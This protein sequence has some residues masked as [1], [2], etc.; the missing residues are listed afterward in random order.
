MIRFARGVLFVAFFLAG[1]SARPGVTGIGENPQILPAAPVAASRPLQHVVIVI[2]ENRSF[3]NFFATFPGADGTTHGTLHTGKVVPLTKHALLFK[4]DLTHTYHT[5]RVAYDNG[6]MDGFDLVPAGSAS[7]PAGAYNYAYVDPPFIAPYWTLAKEYVLADH[8]F[9]TQGSGSF[10]AH[11]DLIAG[12]S[13][14][15]ATRS[16][17]DLPSIGPPWGCDSPPGTVTSLI[18]TNDVYETNAGPYPCYAYA[19]LRDLLDRKHV[20]WK[21]YTPYYKANGGAIWNAFEAIKAVRDGSEWKTNVSEPQTNVFKDIANK[22]LPAVSWV[23]PQANDSDHPGEPEDH[24]PSWVA[25][26][27]NA[28]G[29]SQ[30]WNT[31][32]IVIVWDDS[33]GFYDHVPPPQLGS[34]GLGFRVPMIVVSPYALKGRVVHTAYEFG[35]VVKFVEDVWGLGRLSQTD[36]RATSIANC[37]DFNAP[38]R[39]F[40]PI[41]AAHSR[42]FFEREPPSSRPVDDD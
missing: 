16:V 1:C 21:Y 13:A 35:S 24:G 18:T 27:V 23:I 29:E 41:A 14:I 26:I 15:D 34:G 36:V 11:Q 37:F 20:S 33:G 19:T 42:A 5:Y 3:D 4:N 9:Q 28:I 22:S 2:Q 7:Q 6:K 38:P 30:Y 39:P 31:T 17:I 25:Q 12:G 32:A 10:T 8:T 40:V